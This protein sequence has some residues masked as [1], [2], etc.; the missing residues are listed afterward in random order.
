MADMPRPHLPYLQR[1]K[2]RQGF[3]YY[4][5]LS[6]ETPRVRVRGDYES[7]E[8]MAAYHAAVNRQEPPEP[9]KPNPKSL[10]WLVARYR[11]S[12]AWAGLSVATRRQRDNIFNH[13]LEVAGLEPYARITK[14][15]IV[16]GVDRRRETPGAARH[17]LQAMRGLFRWAVSVDH[18]EHDPTEGVKVKRPKTDGFAVWP[19]EWCAAYEKRWPLGTKERVWYEV[20]L[21]A[22]LR[23]GDA[24]RF[25]RQHVKIVEVEIGGEMV[26]QR[27]AMVRAEKN[28]EVAYFLVSD[29]LQRALDTG[30]IGELTYIVGVKGKPLTKESFGN[31]FG[32]A[33]RAAGVPGS[34]H[35]IR[36]AKATDEVERGASGAK[37]DAMFGWRTGSN[38]S[39]I[40]IKKA[41]RAKL[42][43]GS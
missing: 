16:H 21:G 5:R 11:E 26:V 31:M 37:L 29:R 23:R 20:L 2:R 36:K 40:Y 25:G 24:V 14:K 19:E 38:T 32:E 35:G 9:A 41:N 15:V 17:F 34:A 12:S 10:A 27:R 13:V 6:R 42:A 28:N 33:C 43:F 7:P 3:A 1:E 18:A 8:F 39:A 4:V 30:P 22:G